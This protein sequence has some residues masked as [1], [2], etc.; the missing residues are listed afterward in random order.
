MTEQGPLTIAEAEEQLDG[1][2]LVP[3]LSGSMDEMKRVRAR[4]LDAGIP[5]LV[6]CPGG[7]GKG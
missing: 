7:A 6:G 4:C 1:L 5:V 2:P 3:V